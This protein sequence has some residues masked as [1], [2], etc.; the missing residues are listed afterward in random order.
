MESL[1]LSDDELRSLVRSAVARV[2]STAPVQPE[3]RTAAPR[4]QVSAAD[5]VHASHLLLA[6]GPTGDAEG[7]CVIE[8]TVRCTHCGYCVSFG[9]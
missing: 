2:R 8:P 5:G 9:H 7:N 1:H 3:M 4:A 6:R